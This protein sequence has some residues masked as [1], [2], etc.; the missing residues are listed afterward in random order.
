MA[1]WTEETKALAVKMYTEGNPTAENSAELLKEIAE[2]LEQT[3]NGVRMI[4][5]KA[6]VYVKKEPAKASATT[7][8]TGTAGGGTGRVSKEV[9]ITNLKA[10]ITKAGGS[11]DAEILDKLTGKAA[12]YL[13]SVVEAIAAKSDD[14]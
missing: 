9:Q 2:Q 13:Q 7:A 5:I 3:A 10:A 4:L 1:A 6:E 11:V 8:K 12:A 14:E